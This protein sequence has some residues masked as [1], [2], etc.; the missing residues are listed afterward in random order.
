MLA[1]FLGSFSCTFVPFVVEI[2]LLVLQVDVL[3]VLDLPS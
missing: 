1:F 3:D 2:L